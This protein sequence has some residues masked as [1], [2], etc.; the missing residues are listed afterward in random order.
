MSKIAPLSEKQVKM[1]RE[2]REAL[3]RL[4]VMS[5]EELRAQTSGRA[6]PNMTSKAGTTARRKLSAV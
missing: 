6:I 3:K 1:A 2:N 5:L 4:P